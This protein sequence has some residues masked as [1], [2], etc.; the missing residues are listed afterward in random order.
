MA[1][2]RRTLPDTDANV[3]PRVSSGR[4]PSRGPVKRSMRA[5]AARA[6]K[7]NDLSTTGVFRCALLAGVS[8]AGLQG[9]IDTGN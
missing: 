4:N 1:A 9:W 3:G 5:T 8:R 6:T 7:G 2:V